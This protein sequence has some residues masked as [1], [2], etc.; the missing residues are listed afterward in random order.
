MNNGYWDRVLRIN[1]SENN[2]VVEKV[3]EKVWKKFLG[4]AGFGA[5]ILLEETPPKLDPLSPENKLIFAVGPFQADKVPGSAKWSVVTKSP[6]TRTFLDSAGGGHFAQMLKGAGYDALIIEGKSLKPVYLYINENNVEIRDAKELWGK[7]TKETAELIKNELGDKISSL[8]IGPAGEIQNPIACIVSDGHSFAGRGGSGA[9][10]GSKNLKAIVCF[11]ERE[12]PC[13]NEEKS[14]KLSLEENK[15]LAESG[16]MVREN[17]TP[18]FMPPYEEIGDVPIKYWT[19]DVWHEGAKKI[20]PP[21]YNEL[22]NVK[23]LFC[24]N[25]PI[26]CHRK[27]EFKDL[28]GKQINGNGPEYE[29]MGMMGPNLLNDNL[30]SIATANDICNTMGIDSVSTGAYIGFLMEC[31]EK[32]LITKEDTDGME[33]KWGDGKV[34]VEL[35]KQIAEL[36]DMGELFTAGIQGAAK[37]I[38]K[39]ADR[40]IVEARNM[41]YP[42]HDPRAVFGLAVNYATGTRGACHERGDVQ[43][44]PMG[45]Y[46][47]ELGMEEPY[48][49]FD[50]DLAAKAAYVSQNVSS[51]YN[52]LTICKFMVKAAGMSLT[53][54]NDL[55]NAITGW[56]WT[57]KDMVSAGE[58]ALTLERM[59]NVRDGLGKNADKLSPKM[60]QPALE[61][62][63]KGK[64]PAPF[65]E[66]L[67]EYYELKG[68]NEDGIPTRETLEELN[69]SEFVR[70][71]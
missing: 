35:T 52:I 62:S 66:S 21:N 56:D 30:I 4:G 29:T 24:A 47:P 39:G 23:P 45:L 57:V 32:G 63:R 59:I 16:K 15:E 1:L 42:S 44:M 31:Y 18:L 33:I 70:Y 22:L 65:E 2:W 34:L 38:G 26:G 12:V 46:Y 5:K 13:Y 53:Q 67:K 49:R 10:M 41:D 11:G 7:N 48:D 27:V 68:W 54:I 43:A 51:L 40:L 25:C 55:F 36:K 19:E 64:V 71:I 37:K 50:I 60:L 69:L 9:V 14:R 8:Y 58:R 20:S 3:D 6:L 61:G 17:G 28:D